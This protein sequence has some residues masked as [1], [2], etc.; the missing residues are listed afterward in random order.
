[1]TPI[2]KELPALLETGFPGISDA[3]NWVTALHPTNQKEIIV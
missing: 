2:E 1:M 3:G